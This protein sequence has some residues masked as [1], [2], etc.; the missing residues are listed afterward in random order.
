[1]GALLSRLSSIFAHLFRTIG[2]G[3]GAADSGA[4]TPGQPVKSSVDL[5]AFEG[6]VFRVFL[7]K[8]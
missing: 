6:S 2:S 5:R 1:M 4:K 3:P 7:L 8:S